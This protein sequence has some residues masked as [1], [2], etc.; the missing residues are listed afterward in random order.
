[1]LLGSQDPDTFWLYILYVSACPLL[2]FNVGFPRSARAAAGVPA[3]SRRS[4][5][6]L[7]TLAYAV[8]VSP[9][10]LAVAS[11]NP[12]SYLGY[13]VPIGGFVSPAASEWH[14]V[15]ATFCLFSVLAGAFLLA[16]APVLSLAS[17]LLI[18]LTTVLSC[19]LHGKRTIVAVVLVVF[20]WALWKRGVLSRSRFPLALA[21]GATALLLFSLWYQQT[22]R[23]PEVSLSTGVGSMYDSTRIDFFRDDR[24]KMTLFAQ[25]HPDELRILEHPGHSFLFTRRSSSRAVPGATSPGRMRR[26]SRAPPSDCTLHALWDGE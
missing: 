12:D 9:L 3:I 18:L 20:G 5:R 25:L 1:M 4:L 16:E 10:P 13:A 21:A 19:W 26:T 17:R 11:P 8:A 14:H 15:L 2:W 23:N 6:A 22:V 24:I 7:R